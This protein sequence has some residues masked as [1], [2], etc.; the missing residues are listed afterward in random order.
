VTVAVRPPPRS[1][2]AQAC[3]RNLGDEGVYL[4]G[5]HDRS[6]SRSNVYIN[7]ALTALGFVLTFYEREPTSILSRLSVSMQRMAVLRPG[8]IEPA[9]LWLLLALFAVGVPVAAVWAFARALRA[10]EVADTEAQSV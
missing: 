6:R 7:D 9:T 2:I 4:G 1:L 8:V 10:D 5:V 3:V